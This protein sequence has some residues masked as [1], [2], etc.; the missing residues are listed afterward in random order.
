MFHQD[1]A[2]SCK[3]YF[4]Y[5]FTKLTR[6]AV[7]LTKK[8]IHEKFSISPINKEHP[9]EMFSITYSSY[10]TE[11]LN[12]EIEAITST[13]HMVIIIRIDSLGNCIHFNIVLTK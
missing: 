1:G 5:C 10:H 8:N 2:L 6:L 3:T 11:P 4:T 12:V 13:V 7:K 9:E